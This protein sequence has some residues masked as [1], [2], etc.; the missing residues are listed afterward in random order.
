MN[1]SLSPEIRFQ[2]LEEQFAAGRTADKIFNGPALEH[3]F[4]DDADI[5]SYGHR[6]EIHGSD[7]IQIMMD[8]DGVVAVRELLLSRY[9]HVN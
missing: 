4:V 2:S 6:D 8:V 5:G 9:A 7:L 1:A 3:G